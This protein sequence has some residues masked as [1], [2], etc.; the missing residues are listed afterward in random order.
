MNPKGWSRPGTELAWRASFVSS[1]TGS[2]WDGVIDVLGVLRTDLAHRSRN[3][4]SSTLDQYV[5]YDVR[6]TGTAT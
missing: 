3:A 1:R 5:R 4:S 6:W 2:P